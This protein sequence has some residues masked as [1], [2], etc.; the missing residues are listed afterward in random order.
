MRVTNRMLSDNFLRDMN[1][2]MGNL[3]TLQRQLS[4]GKEISRASDD[5]FRVSRSMQLN[6]DID[7]NLQYNKNILNAEHWLDTTDGALNQAEEVLSKVRD[8]LL[9]AG[10]ASYSDSQRT[11]IKNEINQR[12]G[13]FSQALNV[14]FQGYYIFGGTRGTVKPMEYGAAVDGATDPNNKL[15]YY[16]PAHTSPAQSLTD[17]NTL[18]QIGVGTSKADLNV[19]ISQGVDVKYNVSAG[20]VVNYKSSN[21]SVTN[22]MDLFKSIINHLDGKDINGAAD[23]T[24]VNKLVNEDLQGVTEAIDNILKVRSEVGA[25]QNRMESAQKQNED[26]NFNMT[27]ILSKTEDIDITQKTM[28]YATMQTVYMA[29]LQTSAK[30][31]QPSLL[32][33]LT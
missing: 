19:E 8:K 24:A 31:I 14:N 20:E 6:T 9:Q 11:A 10:D 1:N 5:P 27:E 23:S 7:S 28:Q 18:S 26:E 4:S 30:V 12:V 21:P 16:D 22:V 13:E 33:Y 15:Y 3:R 17:T 29:S 25:M 2:N 32:N